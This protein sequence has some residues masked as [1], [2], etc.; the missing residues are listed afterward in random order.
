[1]KQQIKAWQQAINA[2]RG[3]KLPVL[4]DA[5]ERLGAFMAYEHYCEVSGRNM[6]PAMANVSSAGSGDASAPKPN[7]FLDNPLL[8]LA[9]AG[10]SALGVSM[11]M[12]YRQRQSSQGLLRDIAGA[13]GKIIEKPFNHI[14]NAVHDFLQPR[15]PH[16]RDKGGGMDR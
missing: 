8:Q 1:M 13:A 11:F 9:A 4:D 12:E 3:Y 5:R 6:E 14:R 10:A 7:R 16:D 2:P 15:N